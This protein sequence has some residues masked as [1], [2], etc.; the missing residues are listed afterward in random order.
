MKV[1]IL[2]SKVTEK[3]TVLLFC[4]LPFGSALA[5]N[6]GN[7]SLANIRQT[8]E[9]F[10]LQELDTTGLRDVSVSTA[11]LDSRLKLQDCELPLEA[12]ST[13]NTRNMTRATVGIRCN[14]EKPWT[15]Y[16]PVSITA[17]VDALFTAR[18]LLRGE[19]VS[20]ADVE[21]RQIPLNQLAANSLSDVDALGDLETI[22]PLRAGS[23]LTLNALRTRQMIEQGQQV[24][25][26][27]G[28]GGLQVKME[29]T[30]MKSGSYGELI[31]VKNTRSG[32]IVEA[33]IQ[34]EG[35]VVV[36]L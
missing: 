15:L 35:T 36:N 16:V 19:V 24:V 7:Q 17:M 27:G 23:P 30:A 29:G 2:T 10:V 21:I 33:A 34:D 14:G 25:I 22:R 20:A 32:R 26:L 9:Q 8:A 1:N 12:F 28:G 18:P 11:S 31:P 6:T 5:E 3:M 13:S 4:L